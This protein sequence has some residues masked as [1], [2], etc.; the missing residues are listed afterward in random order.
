M[1]QRSQ[2]KSYFLRGDF[3]RLESVVAGLAEARREL[4]EVRA[5][6][7]SAREAVVKTTEEAAAA[8]AEAARREAAKKEATSIRRKFTEARTD[9]SMLRIRARG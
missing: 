6:A 3:N 1:L 5:D 8:G 9:A 4:D 7:A 2:D